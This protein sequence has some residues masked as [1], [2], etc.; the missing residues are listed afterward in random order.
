ML[1]VLLAATPSL[2]KARHC[3]CLRWCRPERVRLPAGRTPEAASTAEES[4]SAHPSAHPCRG[5]GL[6]GEPSPP[7]LMGLSVLT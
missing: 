5:K 4:R 1:L 6:C 2:S 3:L 7:A